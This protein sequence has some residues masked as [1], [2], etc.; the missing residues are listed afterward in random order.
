MIQVCVDCKKEFE[1]PAPVHGGQRKQRCEAC[2]KLHARQ[3]DAAARERHKAAIIARAKEAERERRAEKADALEAPA[4]NVEPEF[5]SA[6][7]SEK[8]GKPHFRDP[9]PKDEQKKP[10]NYPSVREVSKLA[11]EAGMSYGQYVAL[12]L[13]RIRS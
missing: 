11:D 1:D 9:K 7:A 2:R 12:K 6:A 5:M 13:N 10:N 3:L 4:E 8:M